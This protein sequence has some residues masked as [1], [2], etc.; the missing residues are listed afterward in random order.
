MTNERCRLR[1]PER[2]AK[3][4]ETVIDLCLAL[5][6]NPV[7]KPLISPFVRSANSIGANYCEADDAET[8]RD[9]RHKIA[10]CRKE[11]RETM[12][13]CRM[14]ARACPS[15]KTPIRALWKEADE[16]NKIFS[17]IF[18]KTNPATTA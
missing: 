8:P 11:S 6:T 12:H 15:H 13:W 3:F 9:F 5:E 1:P 17:S 16:L 18:R 10:L 2:T 14:L 4:G 7:V